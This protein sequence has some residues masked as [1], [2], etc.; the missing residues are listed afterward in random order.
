MHVGSHQESIISLTL[1][2]TGMFQ[3]FFETFQYKVHDNPFSN[4]TVITS[5]EEQLG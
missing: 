3:Q 5:E 4:F 2:T 1:T